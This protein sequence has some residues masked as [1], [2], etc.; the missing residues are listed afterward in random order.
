[1]APEHHLV[2][3]VYLAA[4]LEGEVVQVQLFLGVSGL[5]RRRRLDV[6]DPLAP[7]DLLAGP[8]EGKQRDER[9]HRLAAPREEVPGDDQAVHAHAEGAEENQRSEPLDEMVLRAE[10]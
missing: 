8:E 3:L 10:V 5:E 7:G 6:E 9:K 1:A 2:H 4:E